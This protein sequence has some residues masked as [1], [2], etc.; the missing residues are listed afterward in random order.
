MDQGESGGCGEED[1]SFAR[2][3]RRLFVESPSH[4]REGLWRG[5]RILVP[6]SIWEGFVVSARGF[7]RRP[8][9]IVRTCVA[10][11][12]LPVH[13]GGRISEGTRGR[14]WPGCCCVTWPV[15]GLFGC[16]WV[17]R[18]ETRKERTLFRSGESGVGA[19]P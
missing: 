16:P 12:C 7:P 4:R 11:R 15:I 9:A 3:V 8:R 5:R 13:V 18:S 1:H 14:S 6:F 19:V 10:C 2:V 17:V